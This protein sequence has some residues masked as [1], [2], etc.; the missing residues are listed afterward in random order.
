MKCYIL[1]FLASALIP[2]MA[3][4]GPAIPDYSITDDG[5]DSVNVSIMD[6]NLQ[7]E[8]Y[9][10]RGIGTCLLTFDKPVELDSL[11]LV[12]L[13]EDERAYETCENLE[14]ST[15]RSGE[16]RIFLISPGE[17]H[18]EPGGLSFPLS[19]RLEDIQVNWIDF[20]RS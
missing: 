4:G 5:V 11:N 1:I 2:L 14:V 13:Y 10:S 6:G 15:G 20:Y 16:E 3:C 9:C 18:L 19:D 7:M 12:L 8:I 17:L